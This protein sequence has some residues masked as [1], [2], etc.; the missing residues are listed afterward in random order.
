MYI[1]IYIYICIYIYIYIYYV[2]YTHTH[3]HTHTKLF[4]LHSRISW[5]YLLLHE[6]NLIKGVM[7]LQYFWTF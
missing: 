3:T 6:I 1:Y 7:C 4:D 5:P 2:L